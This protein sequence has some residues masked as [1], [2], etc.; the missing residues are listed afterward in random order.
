VKEW[1]EARNTKALLR[2]EYPIGGFN[3]MMTRHEAAAVIGVKC[4]IVRLSDDSE[5]ALTRR[6]LAERYKKVMMLNHPDRGGS[7]YLAMKINEARRVL[8]RYCR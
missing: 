1:K 3:D 8:M 5:Q 7:P 4:A 2:F 6:K